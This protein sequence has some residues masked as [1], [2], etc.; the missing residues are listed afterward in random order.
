MHSGVGQGRLGIM[1]EAR[2][3]GARWKERAAALK[4]EGHVLYLACRDPRVPLLPRV[5]A[6]LVVAYALSPIDLIPD[7]IPVLGYLDDLVIVP[8]GLAL[9]IR[10]IPPEILR[11]HRNRVR[12]MSSTTRASSRAGVAIVVVLWVLVAAGLVWV[13]RPLV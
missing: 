12:G 8:L 7:F 6:V 10:L 9:A 4:A 3:L 1:D 13:I 2:T 11:E 5:L